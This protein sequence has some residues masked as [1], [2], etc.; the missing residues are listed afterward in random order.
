[1][2][3][4]RPTYNDDIDLFETIKTLWHGKWV[5]SAFVATAVLLGGVFLLTKDTVFESKVIFSVYTIPPFYEADKVST[6]FQ[7]RFYS[8][9]VF[10]KWKQNN[11]NTS[12]AFED[13]SS[14]KVV[15][16]F[17]L[18][19]SRSDQLATFA[20]EKNGVSFLLVK[21]N[22]LPILGDF[23]K[24]ANHVNIMLKDEYVIRAKAELNMIE[25]R[26]NDLGKA[27]SNVVE[28]V[29]SIDRYIVTAEQGANVFNIQRPTMPTKVFPKT[30]LI[31][32]LSLISGGFVGAL[33]VLIMNA[34]KRE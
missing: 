14:T 5:I 4:V 9:S 17:V 23:Y 32:A 16:G 2:S 22:Q 19:K 28:T 27:D 33:Y 24:Y 12:I 29:L 11:S 10:D 6:D 3:E 7:K 31:L 1:M 25:S 15:D 26:F 18:S 21:S 30:S 20:T 13:F 34:T 8:I